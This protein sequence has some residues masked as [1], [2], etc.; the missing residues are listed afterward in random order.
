LLTAFGDL[1]GF[2]SDPEITLEANPGTLEGGGEEKLRGFRAAGINRISFGAQ[3]FRA[4]HLATLGRIHSA[5]ET[6]DAFDAARRAGFENLSCDL[7]YG[8]PGQ[9]IED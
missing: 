6:L 4:E 1:W 9:T 8:V 2:S 3:S 7:I 5:A